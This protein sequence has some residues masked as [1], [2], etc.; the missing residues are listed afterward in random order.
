[1]RAA[2]A[3]TAP[4]YT[5]QIPRARCRTRK[6]QPPPCLTQM[7]RRCP[8]LALQ[9]HARTATASERRLLC[10]QQL[11]ARSDPA[12]RTRSSGGLRG[13]PPWVDLGWQCP[14]GPAGP[15]RTVARVGK[16]ATQV[17][18]GASRPPHRGKGPHVA[19]AACAGS[20]HWNAH[21]ACPGAGLAASPA[22]VGRGGRSTGQAVARC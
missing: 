21:C 5:P 9:S 8:A 17:W 19:R 22:C 11:V 13:A 12:P 20:A 7:A 16:P 14:E 2:R 10:R 18:H 1:M 15:S 3:A 6:R 4:H